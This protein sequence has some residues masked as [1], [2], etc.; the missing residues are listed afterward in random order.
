MVL[1]LV[2]HILFEACVGVRLRQWLGLSIE[3]NI[4][5]GS[6]AV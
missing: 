5:K 6:V 4:F 3:T 1:V 2:E